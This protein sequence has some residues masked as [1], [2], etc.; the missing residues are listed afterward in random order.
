MAFTWQNSDNIFISSD[1]IKEIQNNL[2]YLD[3][4]VACITERSGYHSS[5]YPSREVG[6]DSSNNTSRRITYQSSRRDINNDTDDYTQYVGDC[7][8]NR[9][10]DFSSVENSEKNGERTG[11]RSG[12]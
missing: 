3:N 7:T 8:D 6:E 12:Y 10:D 11:A 5:Y 2:D 4:N 9:N 1:L